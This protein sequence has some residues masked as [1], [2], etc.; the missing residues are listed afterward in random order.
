MSGITLRKMSDT[1]YA[2]FKSSTVKSFAAGNVTAGNWQ[3]TGAEDRAGSMLAE[4]GI[5]EI[6]LHVFGHNTPARAL[7]Q[8]IGYVEADVTMRKQILSQG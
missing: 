4:E 3:A 7:Y 2:S 8:K 6:E 5:R 1:E